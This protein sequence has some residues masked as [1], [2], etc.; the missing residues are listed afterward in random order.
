MQRARTR[1]SVSTRRKNSAQ[2]EAEDDFKIKDRLEAL[3]FAETLQGT[4]S[5]NANPG[6]GSIG[7]L[8]NWM[9]KTAATIQRAVQTHSHLSSTRSVIPNRGTL[10]K[11]ILKKYYW[12]H[13]VGFL[14]EWRD[15]RPRPRTA[16]SAS[17]SRPGEDARLSTGWIRPP[18]AYNAG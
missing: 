8:L 10:R 17:A 18:A 1:A 2:A 9:P 12:R 15:G 6:K 14:G 5:P 3:L 16:G 13:T 11:G 4:L 7:G